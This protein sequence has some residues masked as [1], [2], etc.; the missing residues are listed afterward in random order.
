MLVDQVEFS[1]SSST[2]KQKSAMCAS[3]VD[4][5]VNGKGNEVLTIQ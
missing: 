1:Q 2:A 5:P 3:A 4:G